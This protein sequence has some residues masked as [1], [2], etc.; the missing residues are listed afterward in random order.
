M[1]EETSKPEE[2]AGAQ[3]PPKANWEFKTEF[4]INTKMKEL[5]HKTIEVSEM[6]SEMLRKK[7][8][9]LTYGG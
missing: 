9:R 4:A 2:S 7:L 6:E 8:E 3:E 5:I 1:A